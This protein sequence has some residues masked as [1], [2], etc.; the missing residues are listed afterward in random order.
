MPK[1]AVVVTA[2]ERAKT[3][4]SL[5]GALDKPPR[6]C[7]GAEAACGWR[8][9]TSCRQR[10]CIVLPAAAWPL[11]PPR[12]AHICLAVQVDVTQPHTSRGNWGCS[13]TCLGSHARRPPAPACQVLPATSFKASAEALD[14]CKLR[15]RRPQSARVILICC[16]VCIVKCL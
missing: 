4:G 12:H 6:G 8:R 14:T 7:R 15:C 3:I 5:S 2:R 10:Q 1:N 13:A 9:C 11:L 16:M